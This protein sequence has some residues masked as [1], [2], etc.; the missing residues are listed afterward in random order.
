MFTI[1]WY[2]LCKN[3]THI[4]LNQMTYWNWHVTLHPFNY[5]I[6]E[7]YRSNWSQIKQNLSVFPFSLSIYLNE[8]V[9]LLSD[10]MMSSVSNAGTQGKSIEYYRM[11]SVVYALDACFSRIG[12]DV[13]LARHFTPLQLQHSRDLSIKLVTNQTKLKRVSIQSFYLFEWKR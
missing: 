12:L 1:Y 11:L 10:Y 3:N 6:H 4:P 7:I 9:N 8:N 5:N 13:E 2:R